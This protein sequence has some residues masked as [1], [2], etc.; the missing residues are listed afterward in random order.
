MSLSGRIG[1]F[2]LFISLILLTIFFATDQAR[3]PAYAYCCSGVLI[4]IL[5]VLLIWRGRT[6]P[7][8][9]SARFG[10]LRRLSGEEQE[11]DE[12]REE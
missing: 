3:Q 11:Q 9:T 7:P 4:L 1:Q 6:P 2:L 10:L 12:E 5:A 8:E